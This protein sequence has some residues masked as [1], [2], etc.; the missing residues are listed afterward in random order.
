MLAAWGRKRSYAPMSQQ[1]DGYGW[2][3]HEDDAGLL[4]GIGAMTRMGEVQATPPTVGFPVTGDSRQQAVNNPAQVRIDAA[5]LRKLD[6]PVPD[7]GNAYD[8]Q[9]RSAVLLFQQ[10]AGSDIVGAPDGLIGPTTRGALEDMVRSLGGNS[11]TIVLPPTPVPLPPSPVPSPD[12]SPVVARDADKTML[13]AGGAV[14]ALALL[15]LG[16]WALSD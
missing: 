16:W 3:G 5:N 12:V 14:A 10:R 7:T 6:Y 15:G 9:F 13:Y 2:S 1:A 11:S 8:P 4:A